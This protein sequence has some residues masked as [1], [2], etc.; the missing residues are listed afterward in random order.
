MTDPYA[1]WNEEADIIRHA[2]NDPFSPYCDMTDEEIK[3]DVYR[4][5]REDEDEGGDWG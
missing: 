5:M 2:E 4:R 3:E 1:H